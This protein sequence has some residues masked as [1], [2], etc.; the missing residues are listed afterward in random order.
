[1]TNNKNNDNRHHLNL[2]TPHKG[3][4]SV[5]GNPFGARGS[6]VD[7]GREESAGEDAKSNSYSLKAEDCGETT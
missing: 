3:P 6:S 7:V 2:K 5:M 4:C 1:M